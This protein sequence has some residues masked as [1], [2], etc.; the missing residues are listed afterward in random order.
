MSFFV[1]ADPGIAAALLSGRKTQMRVLAHG[2]LASVEPGDRIQVRESVI[3]ARIVAGAIH[4]TSRNRADL[5][6]FA[7]GWR[8]HRDGSH[9]RGRRP[10]DE[11]SQWLGPMHMPAWATRL[12]L[13]VAWARPDRLSAMTRAQARAEGVVPLAGG[14]LWR[15]PKPIRGLYL[16]PRRAVQ[17]HWDLLHSPGERWADDPDVVAIGFQVER[18][19][20][21]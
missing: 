13:T 14:L 7:D 3:P 8:Q 19:G 11:Y 2:P 9:D 16:D 15:W 12:T 1:I 17:A 21:R 5:A 10:S 4:A 6:I 20:S 18:G